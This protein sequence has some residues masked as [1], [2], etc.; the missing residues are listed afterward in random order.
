MPY[1]TCAHH[2]SFSEFP[3]KK[4]RSFLTSTDVNKYKLQKTMTSTTFSKSRLHFPPNSRSPYIPFY[5]QSKVT[6]WSVKATHN[7]VNHSMTSYAAVWEGGASEQEGSE[8]KYRNS[9]TCSLTP[10]GGWLMQSPGKRLGTH[11]TGDC[12]GRSGRVRKISSHTGNSIP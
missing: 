9:S 3:F 11:F 10:E 1:F 5:P 8:V 2:K 12:V 4:C 6:A 7:A